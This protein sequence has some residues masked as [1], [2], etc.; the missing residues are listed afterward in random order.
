[1]LYPYIPR[2]VIAFLLTLG[3]WGV[4]IAASLDSP[5]FGGSGAGSAGDDLSDVRSAPPL[6]NDIH[7]NQCEW[8]YWLVRRL[9]ANADEP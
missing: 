1:M 5:T 9:P 4:W 7:E 2:Q 6:S 3:C 8:R